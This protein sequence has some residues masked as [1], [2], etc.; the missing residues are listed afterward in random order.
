MAEYYRV[1]VKA[2]AIFT[3]VVIADSLE[4]AKLVA[5]ELNLNELSLDDYE[6]ISTNVE[7]KF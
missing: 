6:V 2:T 5:E 3:G 1:E 7:V 4:D